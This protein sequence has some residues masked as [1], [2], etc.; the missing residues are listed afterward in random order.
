M[1]GKIAE[2]VETAERRGALVG[3]LEHGQRS[4]VT[5]QGLTE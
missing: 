4:G 5:E 1:V 3:V 2:R